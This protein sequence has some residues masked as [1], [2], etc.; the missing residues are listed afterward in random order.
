VSLAETGGED[1]HAPR[2]RRS[3]HIH[4]FRF[5]MKKVNPATTAQSVQKNT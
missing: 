3:P 4:F 2:R 5:T 1:E